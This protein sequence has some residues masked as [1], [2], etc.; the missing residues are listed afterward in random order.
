[1][2]SLL[3]LRPGDRFHV[4]MISR[5]TGF[6]PARCT[7]NCASWRVRAALA[8]PSGNQVL[9]QRERKFL[10]FRRALGHPRQDAGAPP[11]LEDHS[12]EHS[13][14]I[15]PPPDRNRSE[16]TVPVRALI[17]ADYRPVVPPLAIIFAA[18]LALWVGPALP[19]SLAGL[20]EAG[21][22]SCC[23]RGAA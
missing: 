22:T 5:L 12:A 11:M 18:A 7:G 23:W 19:P 10:D 15:P 17:A 21:P 9:V 16:R 14:E 2:L 4:R 3:Y 20:K 13:I 1:V 6:P 8:E